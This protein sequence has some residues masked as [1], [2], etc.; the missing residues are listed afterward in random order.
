MSLL[1]GYVFCL[2]RHPPPPVPADRERRG[3]ALGVCGR[4]GQLRSASQRSAGRLPVYDWLLIIFSPITTLHL[5]YKHVQTQYIILAPHAY[6]SLFQPVPP[7]AKTNRC[8]VLII[9]VAV[10]VS[11]AGTW[12]WIPSGALALER[13]PRWIRCHICK[14]YKRTASLISRPDD[15]ERLC[16][17]GVPARAAVRSALPGPDSCSTVGAGVS[18]LPPTAW[19]LV[20]RPA[21]AWDPIAGKLQCKAIARRRTPGLTC[22][23]FKVT[24]CEGDELLFGSA[25]NVAFRLVWYP[26]RQRLYQMPNLSSLKSWRSL[27]STCLTCM[28]QSI[29]RNA[30]SIQHLRVVPS[31]QRVQRAQDLRRA[32]LLRWYPYRARCPS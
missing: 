5:S 11:R 13:N 21:A 22:S 28:H 16:P 19:S 15:T 17:I 10:D 29:T 23:S 20:I 9:T 2:R 3:S 4:R 26:T 24:L 18:C 32:E 25:M 30:V 8:D 27:S 31:L 12:W 14:P 6:V 1:V 7:E